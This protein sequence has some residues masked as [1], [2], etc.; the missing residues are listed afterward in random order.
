MT[1]YL[2]AQPRFKVLIPDYSLLL[3]SLK[4]VNFLSDRNPTGNSTPAVHRW[5]RISSNI[6]FCHTVCIEDY[7]HK[8]TQTQFLI[9]RSSQWLMIHLHLQGNFYVNSLH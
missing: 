3:V 7:N 4:S 2:A 8:L 9:R 5:R 1:K 6:M